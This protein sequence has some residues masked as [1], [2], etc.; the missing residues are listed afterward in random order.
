MATSMQDRCQAIEMCGGV[1]YASRAD[2]H[3]VPV[4]DVPHSCGMN[5]QEHE[6]RQRQALLFEP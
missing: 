4:E 3:L 5:A 2:E 1:F 6:E